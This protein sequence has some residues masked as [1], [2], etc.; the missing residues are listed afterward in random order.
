M[1]AGR[2][3]QM[4][5][6]LW[7]DRETAILLL[8]CPADYALYCSLPAFAADLTPR[9]VYWLTGCAS[10][11]VLLSLRVSP[12]CLPHCTS[13]RGPTFRPDAHFDRAYHYSRSC[14]RAPNA[15]PPYQMMLPLLL[16]Q[17]PHQ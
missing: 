2:P 14:Y 3:L 10:V 16:A 6:Y 7:P 4:S 1:A 17:Q 13:P 15:N 12:R 8:I 5:L 11:G 9:V